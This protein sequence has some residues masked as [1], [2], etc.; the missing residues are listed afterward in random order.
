MHLVMVLLL[1][2]IPSPI[3]DACII[4]DPEPFI[5]VDMGMIYE[6]CRER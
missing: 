4:H 5:I 1:L 3:E 2:M 6:L